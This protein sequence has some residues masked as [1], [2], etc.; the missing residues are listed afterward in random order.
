MISDAVGCNN[1]EPANT[2][3]I[4]TECKRRFIFPCFSTGHKSVCVL[5]R[6]PCGL[7]SELALLSLPLI[8]SRQH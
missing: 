2:A 1:K 6:E 3:G 4:N 8:M 7:I 5:V